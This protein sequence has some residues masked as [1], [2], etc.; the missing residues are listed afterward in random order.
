MT[1]TQQ[2]ARVSRR[3]VM[4]TGAGLV[5]AG[6]VAGAAGGAVATHVLG[7]GGPSGATGNPKLPVMVY[8]RDADTGRFDVFVGDSRLTVVDP[9]FAARLVRAAQAA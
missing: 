5:A 1:S 7:G 4:A 6:A 3:R 9:N 2:P 8:L